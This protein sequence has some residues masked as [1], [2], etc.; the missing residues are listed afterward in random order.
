ML[1][2]AGVKVKSAP[3]DFDESIIK[4]KMLG[5]NARPSKI[6]DKLA[7]GK[8]M[9]V[10]ARFPDH[11]VLGADQV[12][13]HNGIIF[14]KPTSLDE[15]RKHLLLLKDSTHDLLSAAVIVLNGQPVWRHIGHA[16]LTMRRFSDEFL[17]GY[18]AQTDSDLFTTV[19]GYK[20]EKH[21]AQLFSSVQGDYFS[22][23][24]LSLLEVLG[25]LR[26]RG[27]CVK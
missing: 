7:E 13:V 27:Y 8:A 6:A 5:E 24:G 25:F 21:G 12:L 14:D 20:L 11:L 15:A 3:A 9:E 23:L 26:L 17:E 19:G 22:V 1:K 18:I 16:S 2:D 10:S 4:K